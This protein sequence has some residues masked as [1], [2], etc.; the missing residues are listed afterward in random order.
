[1]TTTRQLTIDTAITDS[2]QE[3][4]HANS[5]DNQPVAL[6]ESD[7]S[8][9]IE[10]Q[11][12]PSEHKSIVVFSIDS[13]THDEKLII[14][15]LP[16]SNSDH[17]SELYFR[18]QLALHMHKTLEYGTEDIAADEWESREF[19][20]QALRIEEALR[21]SLADF[22][23]TTYRA[24]RLP[25]HMSFLKGIKKVQGAMDVLNTI[26]FRVTDFNRIRG[27]KQGAFLSDT[28]KENLGHFGTSL[29]ALDVFVES[30][31]PLYKTFF[32]KK[33]NGE[34]KG[35]SNSSL[36]RFTNHMQKGN[37]PFRFFDA[38]VGLTLS[39][40]GYVTA[41]IAL[42][43]ASPAV[44]VL[45]ACY[46][47][48]RNVNQYNK[49][50]KKIADSIVTV[51]AHGDF[52]TT[53]L[54]NI[55][56]KI[57]QKEALIKIYRQH[58]EVLKEEE[59]YVKKLQNLNCQTTDLLEDNKSKV[60]DLLKENKNNQQA[61]NCKIIDLLEENKDNQ[62]EI[63]KL[64]KER[65]QYHA[66]LVSLQH[67][68]QRTEVKKKS[69]KKEGYERIARAVVLTVGG[70]LCAYL[71]P[72]ITIFIAWGLLAMGVYMLGCRIVSIYK[73]YNASIQKE[74]DESD[75][76]RRS[77]V[78]NSK[79]TPNHTY[80]KTKQCNNTH[81]K[82]FVI[83][84]EYKAP[85]SSPVAKS[86]DNITSSD[87]KPF[88]NVDST[89]SLISLDDSSSALNSPILPFSPGEGELQRSVRFRSTA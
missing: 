11:I 4:K 20:L 44:V 36:K 3:S 83:L 24:H 80:T 50:L 89:S 57:A 37:R 2:P 51:S 45:M 82:C 59:L 63:I 33:T 75:L 29:S 73:N 8:P 81:A 38:T 28:A 39:I 85:P 54:T 71:A 13:L 65:Q 30:F 70:L 46:G 61:L 74:V 48:W 53:E 47:A 49:T 26:R 1:M 23:S 58:L 43:V 32:A 10:K 88:R 72:Q 52:I 12:D 34:K 18:H 84:E 14:A 25:T 55:H 62:I 15:S 60:T 67:I 6:S 17:P 79:P 27:L 69:A 5:N 21:K 42:T 7:T 35:E 86:G 77:T 9:L 19:V 78:A 41:G 22:E 87:E 56:A 68:K 76:V 31:G 66:Q 16:F 64:T 40:V